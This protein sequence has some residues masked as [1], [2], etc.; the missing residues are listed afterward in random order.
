MADITFIAD[1]MLGKLA[2]RLRMLG[3]DVLYSNVAEDDEIVRIAES[4]HRIILTRD[5][6]LCNRRMSTRC[7]LI[8]SGK[9]REQI[10]QV[11]AAFE[12]E[13]FEA[14][15]RCLE[16]NTLLESIPRGAVSERVPPFVHQTQEKFAA[17]P[18]CGRVSWQGTHVDQMRRHIP[19]QL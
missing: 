3:I 12:L 5:V 13:A 7:L 14:F 4:E 1:V 18:S 17:C 8:D 19:T 9:D 2:R 16:C 10:R 6:G 15:S 11:I